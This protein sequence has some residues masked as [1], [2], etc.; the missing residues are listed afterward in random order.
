MVHITKQVFQVVQAAV[1]V[2]MAHLLTTMV[3]QLNQINL[4]NQEITDLDLMVVHQV[5]EVH[6]Q[7]AA[8]VVLAVL[9]K[10]DLDQILTLNQVQQLQAVTEN[11]IQ[12]QAVR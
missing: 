5:K 1:Q 6:K 3:V 4:V 8:A 7:V 10:T 12:F 2:E 11:F 9:V